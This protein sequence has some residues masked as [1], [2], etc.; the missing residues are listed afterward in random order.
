MNTEINIRPATADDHTALADAFYK[1]WLDNGMKEKDFIPDWKPAT[2]AF[3]SQT[4]RNNKGRAFVAEKDN[5]VIGAAQCLISRKL[6]PEALKPDVRMD[7]YIWGVYVDHTHRRKG[8]ATRL[9]EACVEYLK[10]IGCT[11]VI[12]HA[13]P[14]GM[15]VYE[16]LGFGHTNE[17]RLIF[18]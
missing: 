1:M 15:P 3:M 12:L 18:S 14:S 7:G 11:R 13:S 17:M 10:G 9:T 4:M 2:L 5:A 6:Y 8:L 16:S